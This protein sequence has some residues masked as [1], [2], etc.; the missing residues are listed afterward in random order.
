MYS[1]YDRH[2][3]IKMIDIRVHI[4]CNYYFIIYIKAIYCVRV[5]LYLAI[6]I[7]IL[8]YTTLYTMNKKLII[9]KFEGDEDSR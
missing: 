4:I 1:Y 5:H 3:V 2:E 6:E 8:F 7:V 9:L